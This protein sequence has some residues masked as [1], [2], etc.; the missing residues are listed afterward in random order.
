MDI[1]PPGLQHATIMPLTTVTVPPYTSTNAVIYGEGDFVV[2]DPGSGDID[3]KAKLASY[4]E[5]RQ[6][7]GHRLVAILLTHHHGDHSKGAKSLADQFCVPIF[8]HEYAQQHLTYDVVP[9]SHNAII[10]LGHQGHLR[11]YYTPGHADDHMV[12]FDESTGCLIAGDMLTDRGT[13]L[14][15]PTEGDLQVYL[16][17]LRFLCDLPMNAIIPA[18]G[19][20]ITKD[21][22]AFL[23]KALRHRYERINAVLH[24]LREAVGPLDATDITYKVYGVSLAD[25][26]VFFAQLSTESS[27]KWLLKA[28]LVTS[29]NYKW[30]LSPHGKDSQ[31]LKDLIERLG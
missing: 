28:D 9:L 10:T 11:A 13:V 23:L 19:A 27:L 3:E 5:H 15:P 17:S 29:T 14:I 26:L 30:Q 25:N 20:C 18:H 4:V 1:K 16:E 21:P 24:A 2:V 8:A 22:K 31:L 6:A 12:F 7:L